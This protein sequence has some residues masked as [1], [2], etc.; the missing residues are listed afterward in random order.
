MKNKHLI[1]DDTCKYNPPYVKTFYKEA[2]YKPVR[3]IKT[4]TYYSKMFVMNGKK[5]YLAGGAGGGVKMCPQN[6]N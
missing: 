6:K 2:Q 1:C 4:N 5:I 3:N